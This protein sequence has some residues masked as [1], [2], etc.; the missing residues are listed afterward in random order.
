MYPWWPMTPQL[1]ISI[2][3]V[4]TTYMARDAITRIGPSLGVV[5]HLETHEG[6]DA[7][8]AHTRMDA[9]NASRSRRP[10]LWRPQHSHQLKSGQI[11][12]WGAPKVTHIRSL[13]ARNTPFPTAQPM[14][15]PTFTHTRS[16]VATRIKRLWRSWQRVGLIILRS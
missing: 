8:V 1:N 7:I 9:R 4:A 14:C 11:M 15:A 12:F 16:H 6:H 5:G 3:Q 10:P 2:L 13:Y